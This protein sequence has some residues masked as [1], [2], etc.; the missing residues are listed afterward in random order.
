MSLFKILFHKFSEENM[1]FM[2][3][4][5][6]IKK[7]LVKRKKSNLKLEASNLNKKGKLYKICM[8][9]MSIYVLF[10]SFAIYA[11]K[12]VNATYINSLFNT[13]INFK[14]FN[15]TLNN[16]LDLR[17]LKDVSSEDD[18]VVNGSI[19]YI[20]IGEDYYLSDNNLAVA[21]DDGVVTYINGK[22]DNYTV[23]VNY[24]NGVMATYYDLVEVNVFSNDRL[25]S[26]DI[27][28]SYNEKVK[29]VFI[30]DNK[31]ISYEDVISF[32]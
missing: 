9:I 17:I 20:E 14:G 1:K 3:K 26:G 18:I 25:Y 5:D 4:I 28:G 10:M 27:M 8:S 15:N 7:N 24:D 22:D 16:L 19:N 32:L 30:K 2:N 31:K 23:I 12:D 29:I 21:L 11:S 6:K 13:N